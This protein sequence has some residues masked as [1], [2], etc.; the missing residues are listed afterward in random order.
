MSCA[1]DTA[2]MCASKTYGVLYEA[3]A[4]LAYELDMPA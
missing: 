1:H 4:P 3:K 2:L